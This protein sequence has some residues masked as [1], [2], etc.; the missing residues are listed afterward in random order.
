MPILATEASQGRG[1]GDAFLD[2]SRN[3]STCPAG[4]AEPRSTVGAPEH[5]LLAWWAGEVHLNAASVLL[6]MPATPSRRALDQHGF[7]RSCQGASPSLSA[8]RAGRR[9]GGSCLS[10]SVLLAT[11]TADAD[12]VHARQRVS[13]DRLGTDQGCTHEFEKS[14][15]FRTGF[16]RASLNCSSRVS[17]ASGPSEPVR[18]FVCEA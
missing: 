3:G 8:V 11:L 14:D 15:S 13:L 6:T 17:P 7:R 12:P 5:R 2:R 4:V 16:R 10:P 1:L 9:G 18:N